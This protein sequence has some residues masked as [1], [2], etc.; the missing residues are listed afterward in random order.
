MSLSL[1]MYPRP[2]LL[3]LVIDEVQVPRPSSGLSVDDIR[4]IIGRIRKAIEDDPGL[5][6]ILGFL[7]EDVPAVYDPDKVDDLGVISSVFRPGIAIELGPRLSRADKQ[8]AANAIE[9]LY[10]GNAESLNQALI[11]GAISVDTWLGSLKKEVSAGHVSTYSAGRSGAWSSITFSEWGRLGQRIRRQNE[12]LKGFAADIQKRGVENISVA[13]L[14][15]RTGLYGSNFRESLEAGIARDR[16]LDPSALP[17]IPGDGST[18]CLVRCKCRW[19]IRPRGRDRFSVSWRLGAAE[20]CKTCLDRSR[21]WVGLEIHKGVMVSAVV[22][23]FHN[24]N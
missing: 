1:T 15:N 11:D 17:A 7:L 10:N 9:A 13:Y 12:F 22:P 20:H 3:N 19:T 21:D 4:E 23:H 8:R 6:D 18:R 24:Q 5:A 16:G 14:N 2:S